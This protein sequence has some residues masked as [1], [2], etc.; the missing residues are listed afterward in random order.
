MNYIRLEPFLPNP[1]NSIEEQPAE[2]LLAMVLWGE[3]RGST[4]EAKVAVASVILNRVAGKPGRFWPLG[5]LGL[6]EK[7]RRVVLKPWQFSCLNANDPNRPKMLEP[8]KYD[9]VWAWNECMAVAAGALDG[10]YKDPTRGA[11]HYYSPAYGPPDERGVRP[12]TNRP[13]WA[14]IHQ[15]TLTLRGFEFF[16]IG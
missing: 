4:V 9:A 3:A 2:A 6:N 1:D 15:P 11:D 7:I 16:K 12:I 8:R 10:L 14:G 5:A 13:A